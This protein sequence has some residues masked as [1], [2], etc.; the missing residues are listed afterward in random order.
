MHTTEK[1]PTEKCLKETKIVKTAQD[2]FNNKNL[3][4][5]INHN[6]KSSNIHNPNKHSKRN[7]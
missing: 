1:D 7:T 5:S 6:S 4:V 2:I 3:F